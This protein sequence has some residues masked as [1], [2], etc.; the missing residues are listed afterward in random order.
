MIQDKKVI[1]LA[2]IFT[3]VPVQDLKE[4]FL[5]KKV[6]KLLF[7]GHPLFYVKGRPG[8]FYELY[9]QGKL[10]KKVQY[11]NRKLPSILQYIKDVCL[12]LYWVLRVGGEWDVI[13]ALDNLNTISGLMLKALGRIRKVV[14]YTIDFV[15]KRFDNAMLNGFYHYLE[16]LAVKYADKTW[17]LTDRVTEGR[18]KLLGMN[19]RVYNKQVIMPIGIWFARFPR[20][21]FSDIDNHTLVY[22]GGLVPHQGIQLALEAAPAIKKEIPDFHFKIIGIGSYEQQLK[23][24]TKKL[25]AEK[26]IHFLGYMEDHR[27][28]EKTLSSCGAAVAMYSEELSK[29]SYYADPSKIK[30]YVAAGL[31][32]ITTS[33]T[34][35]ANDLEKSKSGIVVAY[36]KE[37]VAKAVIKLFKDEKMQKKYRENAIAFASKFDWNAIL[38]QSLADIY[39]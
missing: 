32:V 29:W 17:N 10:V 22:A 7:I 3:T 24:L 39:S 19:K 35:I 31:P 18:E 23:A 14:Y 37:D 30:T 28:V 5:E 38:D 11:T 34:Q 20:K 9:E 12:T 15:P 16:K 25:N 33:L 6:E 36:K 26:Y 1:L 4:Y 2:H 8:A 13:I 21:K 27:D